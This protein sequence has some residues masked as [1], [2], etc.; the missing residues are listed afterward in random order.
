V[1]SV[2]PD[3]VAAVR[4]AVDTWGDLPRV[5]P[6]AMGRPAA[7]AFLGTFRWCATPADLPEV[8]T[9]L[10]A[11]DRRLPA[12]LHPFGGDVLVVLD[13][14]RYAAGVGL[15]RHNRYG[16]ELAVG[17]EPAFRGR[18]LAARLC[19]QAA[20]HVLAA[21]AVPTYLH[22]PANLASAHTGAAAGFADRG[23]QVLGMTPLRPGRAVG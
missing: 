10:P 5:L 16:V 12:W 9:W 11:T 20:R 13:G 19:A 17:T 2:P 22:D 6:Q 18:G 21:G 14:E 7:S 4:A 3:H 15:K 1:V 23:W 8:G